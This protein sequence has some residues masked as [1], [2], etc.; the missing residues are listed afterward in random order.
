MLVV[1]KKSAAF[2]AI[3]DAKAA[4]AKFK[5]ADGARSAARN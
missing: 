5:A 2:K 4:I 3:D 1:R